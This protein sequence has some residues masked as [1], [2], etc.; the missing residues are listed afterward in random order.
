[1]FNDIGNGDYLVNPFQA[2]R[3]L[4]QSRQGRHRNRPGKGPAPWIH[5][6]TGLGWQAER[7]DKNETE[8]EGEKREEAGRQRREREREREV[9][10]LPRCQ[11][12]S[13][14]N[15]DSA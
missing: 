11:Q 14:S 3:P 12:L 9:V 4:V 5:T 8:R 13:G 2:I 15:Q 10:L 6:W 7:G 1:M